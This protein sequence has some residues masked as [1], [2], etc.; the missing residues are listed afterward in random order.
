MN[1]SLRIKKYDF[2]V[3]NDA[4]Y[5]AQL[6]LKNVRLGFYFRATTVFV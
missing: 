3:G 6:L 2:C 5:Q 4:I 1:G